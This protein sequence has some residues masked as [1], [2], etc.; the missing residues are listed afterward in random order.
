MPKLLFKSRVV[1]D[2]TYIIISTKK[3]KEEIAK[4]DLRE[5]KKL[6]NFS[7]FQ[8]GNRVEKGK[9]LTP[10]ALSLKL[11]QLTHDLKDLFPPKL[12]SIK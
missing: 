12:Y 8:G 2:I 9:D 10:L 11:E 7:F 5:E 4:I 1:Q 3:K 6:Y